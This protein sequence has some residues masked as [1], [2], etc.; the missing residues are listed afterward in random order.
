LL[1]FFVCGVW[2]KA[3][4]TP[5]R[6]SLMS[7]RKR[8]TQNSYLFLCLPLAESVYCEK[9]VGSYEPSNDTQSVAQSEWVR[10]V[11]LH[12]NSGNRDPWK[13]YHKNV[14]RFIRAHLPERKSLTWVEIGTAFGMTTDY[15]LSELPNVIAHVVD[16][17][18][19]DYD[20]SDNTARVLSR[21]RRNGN[22]SG[23]T[24]SH[25]W[26]SALVRQQLQQ[27]RACRYHLYRRRSTESAVYFSNAS[28]DV[29]F[30]DGLHTYDGVM[31]D[32]IS[33]W[34]KLKAQSLLILNDWKAVWNCPCRHNRIEGRC[35]CAFPGV[36]KAG[37][38]FLATKGL[39]T[40]II[41]EGPVGTTNAAVVLG[42]TNQAIPRNNTCSF[43]G[44]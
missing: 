24:F 18:Q 20:M 36:K 15:V 38:E 7:N 14:V 10:T 37:C 42:M 33:Y 19:G 26:A 11:M 23:T 9:K 27:Q 13:L 40:R 17:C 31:N 25:A 44:K 4:T 21:Y 3:G 12:E 43:M 28:I 39:S 32:L 22:M 1:W 5:A 30:V 2:K 41:E 34:P 29:L 6:R 16:P 35:H 8:N